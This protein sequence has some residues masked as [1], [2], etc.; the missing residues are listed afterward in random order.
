VND[1]VLELKA[2]NMQKVIRPEATVYYS[3]GTQ[4]RRKNRQ[5]YYGCPLRRNSAFVTRRGIAVLM[6]TWHCYANVTT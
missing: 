3:A 2:R 4:R 6:S 1:V 5:E